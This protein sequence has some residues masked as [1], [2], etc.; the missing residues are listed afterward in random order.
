MW[1][2]RLVICLLS[3]VYCLSPVL[4]SEQLSEMLIEKPQ[5]LD[6][7]WNLLELESQIWYQL[8]QKKIEQYKILESQRKSDQ[9]II[10]NLQNQ[11]MQDKKSL[12]NLEELQVKSLNRITELETLLKEAENLLQAEAIR[13]Q[14][15]KVKAGIIGTAVGLVAGSATVGIIWLLNTN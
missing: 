10:K 1:T 14:A 8:M 9:D 4:C 11:L 12:T 2:K 15:E 7:V 3:L 6:E 13:M 5:T